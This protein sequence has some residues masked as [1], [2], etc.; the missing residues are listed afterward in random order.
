MIMQKIPLDDWH[1]QAFRVAINLHPKCWARRRR[2]ACL[3]IFRIT[4]PKVCNEQP[5]LYRVRSKTFA[6]LDS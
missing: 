3:P 4:H 1:T 2:R 6:V 5:R